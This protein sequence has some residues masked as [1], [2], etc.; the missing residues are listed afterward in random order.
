M[1]PQERKIAVPIMTTL[2]LCLGAWF[3]GFQ[4][5]QSF[6]DISAIRS[7]K[8]A[9]V[10][11]LTVVANQALHTLDDSG[12]RVARQNLQSFGLKAAPNGMDWTVDALG[13]VEA[14]FFEDNPVRVLSCV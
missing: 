12:R 7:F 10:L 3:Y 5:I 1:T 9:S 11:R 6:E 4:I 2:L 8:A 14:W 13:Q